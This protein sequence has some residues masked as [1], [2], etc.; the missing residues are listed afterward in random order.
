MRVQKW[1]KLTLA[2][3]L[4]IGGTLLPVIGVHKWEKLTL[5]TLLQVGGISF[6]IVDLQL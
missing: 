4:Q 2:T 3:M 1:E 6:A 5:A